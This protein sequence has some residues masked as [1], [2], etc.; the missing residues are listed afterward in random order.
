MPTR[1]QRLF[2]INMRNAE[3]AVASYRYGWPIDPVRQAQISDEINEGIEKQDA[4]LVKLLQASPIPKQFAASFNPNSPPQVGRLLYDILECPVKMRTPVGKPSAGK[5]ALEQIMLMS[6]E[7]AKSLAQCLRQ[8]K[9][10]TKLKEAYI[11]NL[12]GISIVRPRAATSA[13]L[14]GRWSYRDPALQTTPPKIKPMFIAHSNQWMVFADLSQAEL[15]NMAQLS[16]CPAMLG[17]YSRGEDIHANTAAASFG[18]TPEEAKTKPFRNPAKVIGLG[19]NY[20]VLDDEGAAAG[21]YPQLI[22]KRP[23][24]TF[25]Q[26]LGA[27]K[28]LKQSRPRVQE[29]KANLLA[30]ALQLDY[31]EE[32]I[33]RRRR[34]F[35][36]KVKDTEAFNFGCQAMTAAIVNDAIWEIHQRLDHSCEGLLLQRHDE[37]G[38]GGPD[39]LRLAQLLLDHLQRTVDVNGNTM[40]YEIDWWV[41]QRWGEGGA[42]IEPKEG[43]FVT[44]KNGEHR[45]FS[46]LTDAIAYATI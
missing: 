33:H 37:L 15:R 16:G 12:Q 40:V 2:A 23:G 42:S 29:Y 21:L 44:A 4:T 35:W 30:R 10:L 25:E 18:C 11:I 45:A 3:I 22:A 34:K 32:P 7:P 24:I 20:S 43:Q 27:I 19:Y 36:G 41:G 6:D 5:E 8:R 39:P 13:Q 26:V 38:L 17:A 28:R 31:V 14:S 9:I 1:R 46:T